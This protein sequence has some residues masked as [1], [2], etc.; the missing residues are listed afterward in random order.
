MIAK[1]RVLFLTALLSMLSQLAIAQA[2]FVSVVQADKGVADC[3]PPKN[4]ELFHDYINNEQK[5][6]LK[7][8]GKNDDQY[9]PT[10]DDQ[11]NF[12]LTRTLTNRV[13]GLQCKIENDSTMSAQNKV[14]YLRGI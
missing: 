10:S 2:D 3:K 6:I 4:R 7:S 5:K 9:T 8:D 14:R 13:D 12:I 1:T 11:I